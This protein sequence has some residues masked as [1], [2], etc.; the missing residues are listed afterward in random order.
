MWTAD[1][2]RRMTRRKN[3]FRAWPDLRR[4]SRSVRRIWGRFL[5][6]IHILSIQ[7][8]IISLRY[9]RTKSGITVCLWDILL[10]LW[11]WPRAGD[12]LSRWRFWRRTRRR[13]IVPN[14]SFLPEC[15][16]KSEHRSTP[17]WVWMRWC[18]GSPPKRTSKNIRWISRHRRRHCWASSMIFWTFLK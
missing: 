8:A 9:M 1:F 12:S 17:C 14:R 3:C 13:P 11:I 16:M 15:P 4:E 18:S 6:P 10:C 5:P 2:L 7:A